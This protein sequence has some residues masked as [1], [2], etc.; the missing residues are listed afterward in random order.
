MNHEPDGTPKIS[1]K[2]AIAKG[3]SH[4]FTG[5]PCK[6]GHVSPR[7]AKTG[8]CMACKREDSR[9]RA[10]ANPERT[11]EVNRASVKRHYDANRAAILEAKR[12]YYRDNA[13]AIKQRARDYRARKAT[14]PGTQ[15]EPITDTK[16]TEGV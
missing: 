11:R 9:R 1:R 2:Q 12:Q 6:A 16:P 8:A 10:Q 14:E 5:K 4:Y 13:E 7:S 15:G 3:Q